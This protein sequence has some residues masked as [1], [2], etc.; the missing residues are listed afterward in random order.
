MRFLNRLNIRNMTVDTKELRVPSW[1]VSI[2]APIIL[3]IVGYVIGL[4]SIHA[5]TEAE[6]S[7]VK[8]D[9]VR[10]E[11]GKADEAVVTMMNNT[12]I[13]IESKLDQHIQKSN[14]KY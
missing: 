8:D 1:V 4:S 2:L 5:K 13:R 12:L 6:I 7:N 11:A 9:I 3:A 14:E 10:I